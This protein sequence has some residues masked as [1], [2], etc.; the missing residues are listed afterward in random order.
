MLHRLLARLAAL[1]ALMLP[2]AAHADWYEVDSAHFTVYSNDNPDKIKAFA[3]DLEKFDKMMRFLRSAE[4][5]VLSKQNRLTV[6]VVG[7]TDDVAKLAGDSF[8]AGFYSGR[9]SGSVAFVP[10]RTGYD[11]D[12]DFG[13]RPILFHEYAHHFMW[14]MYPNTPYPLWF[15]EGFAEF[16][17]TAKFGKDGSVTFGSPLNYRA[18][19]ILDGN[20]LPVEKLMTADTLKLGEMQRD[21]LYGRGWLLMH[22]LVMSGARDG[23]LEAYIHAINEG[24]AGLEAASVFGDLHALDRELE[25]YKR[26]KFRAYTVPAA[27]LPIGEI[28]VRKLTPGEAATM[29]ARILSKNGVTE[30]TAPGVYEMAKR[31]CAPYPN[32]PGAQMVLAEAAFDAGDYVAAEA[33]AD[34]AIAADATREDGYLYK[35][36]ARMAVAKKAHDTS[37]PTWGAIRKL[38]AAAN[39]LETEDPEP[40]ILYFQ[41]FLDAEQVPPK[42]ARE[43]MYKAFELAPQDDDLRML[44]AQVYL[45]DGQPAM[46]RLLLKP[47]AYDPHNKEMAQA[48]AALIKQ[49]DAKN[50]PAPTPAETKKTDKPASS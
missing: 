20:I 47:L 2:I 37:K 36:M 33:A 40:L 29:R 46:A 41:S 17:A 23:Q 14:S 44:V 3:T 27:K 22:Y 39:K 19:T 28:T 7:D 6:Y 13:P 8:V 43:G 30:K 25:K 49:I 1:L 38:I 12:D 42:L 32:D 48:A 50:P 21:G 9:A 31:I 11:G 16:Y 26:G 10:R 5:P 45:N 34:R 15:S 35:A 24:K 4:D 18:Q